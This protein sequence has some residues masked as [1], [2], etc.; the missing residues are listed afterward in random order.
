MRPFVSGDPISS[1]IEDEVVCG[2]VI[3][4]GHGVIRWLRLDHGT[5]CDDATNTEGIEWA[6]GHITGEAAEALLAANK[7][8][9][10]AA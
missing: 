9:R 2:S 7:L 10:S 5:I 1:V 6:R 8:A 4:V 3:D